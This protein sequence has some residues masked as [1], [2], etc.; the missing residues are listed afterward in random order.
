M[1]F[2]LSVSLHLASPLHDDKDNFLER[3]EYNRE[4]KVASMALLG[5]MDPRRPSEVI[6]IKERETMAIAETVGWI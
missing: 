3:Y 4:R 6:E 5:T 1:S 2:L